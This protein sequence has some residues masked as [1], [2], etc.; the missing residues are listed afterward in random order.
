MWRV[1]WREISCRPSLYSSAE[2]LARNRALELVML[3]DRVHRVVCQVDV[4]IPRSPF[5]GLGILFEHHACELTLS[6]ALYEIPLDRG[7]VRRDHVERERV[8]EN[9]PLPRQDRDQG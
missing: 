5:H 6:D 2:S 9:W 3:R 1:R 8:E 7:P 4:G